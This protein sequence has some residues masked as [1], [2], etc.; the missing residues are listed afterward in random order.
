MVNR[1]LSAKRQN[2]QFV[3]FAH[4]YAVSVSEFVRNLIAETLPELSQPALTA[5]ILSEKTVP[6]S[7]CLL[8]ATWTCD[9]R[10]KRQLK[11]HLAKKLPPNCTA[12]CVLNVGDDEEE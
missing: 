2:N 8:V 12:A 3:V 4:D 11:A 7:L 6:C 5:R 1:C 9:K 10:N